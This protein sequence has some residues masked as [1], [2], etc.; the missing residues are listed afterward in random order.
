MVTY[1][2]GPSQLGLRRIKTRLTLVP[3][4]LEPTQPLRASAYSDV[5]L[6]V[7]GGT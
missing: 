3:D 6:L 4:D 5:V 2:T 7:C 1:D